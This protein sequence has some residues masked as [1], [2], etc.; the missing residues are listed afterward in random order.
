[1]AKINKRGRGREGGRKPHLRGR[2]FYLNTAF[3]YNIF[4]FSTNS[5]FSTSSQ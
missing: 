1:M 5:S 3:S 2:F 4:Y